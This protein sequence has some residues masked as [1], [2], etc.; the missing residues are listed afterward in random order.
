MAPA[1]SRRRDSCH[2][3]CCSSGASRL[4]MCQTETGSVSGS[5]G[6]STAAAALILPTAEVSSI[7]GMEQFVNEEP[8]IS[9]SRNQS[10][11]VVCITVKGKYVLN[12]QSILRFLG[13]AFR[14]IRLGATAPTLNNTSTAECFSFSQQGGRMSARA[15]VMTREVLENTAF[16]FQPEYYER[17]PSVVVQRSSQCSTLKHP[18]DRRGTMPPPN[19]I[20]PTW[21]TCKS[22]EAEPLLARPGQWRLAIY[23]AK[24]LARSRCQMAQLLI[25][26]IHR[27][28]IVVDIIEHPRQGRHRRRRYTTKPLCD[29]DMESTIAILFLSNGLPKKARNTVP[30]NCHLTIFRRH[31]HIAEKMVSFADKYVGL[32]VIGSFLF[33][34]QVAVLN[35]SL[36]F[37]TLHFQACGDSLTTNCPAAVSYESYANS[38]VF[39]GAAVGSLAAGQLVSVG[40]RVSMLVCHMISILAALIG[41]FATGYPMFIAGRLVAGLCVGLI[42]VATPTFISE[43]CPA[44]TRGSRGMVCSSSSATI[45]TVSQRGDRFNV[46][47]F[48]RRAICVTGFLNNFRSVHQL[49][50][51]LGIFTAILLGLFL[52]SFPTPEAPEFSIWQP[53]LMQLYPGIISLFSV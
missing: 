37:F 47:A 29:M 20:R 28:C 40:R 43:I 3:C 9:V 45:K 12:R 14:E 49:N 36:S 4:T 5:R 22:P 25:A 42:T 7:G 21:R 2:L 13:R 48:R 11:S 39:L 6:P 35:T 19:C 24:V 34:Y 30:T 15:K 16:L 18:T 1:I 33:G 52:P 23:N 41:F 17:L 51:G 10:L 31:R 44:H 46:A 50:I 38:V 26:V 32:A 53:K 27:I 8:L